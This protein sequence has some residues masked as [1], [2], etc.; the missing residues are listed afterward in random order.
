MKKFIPLTLTAV[1]AIAMVFAIAPSDY[2]QT[3]HVSTPSAGTSTDASFV[4]NVL[5]GAAIEDQLTV[6]GIEP[7]NAA[8][9]LTLEG[10]GAVG[11]VVQA[12]NDGNV[13][14]GQILFTID[15]DDDASD[16]FSVDASGDIRSSGSLTLDSTGIAAG[17]DMFTIGD[18]KGIVTLFLIDASGDVSITGTLDID[19]IAVAELTPLFT[20]G[21]DEDG[22]E[23]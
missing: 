15:D 20:I 9:A 13:G 5:T 16:L 8:T 14:E 18:P 17:E 11:V 2:A 4:A 10:T 7:E 22:A 12:G 23:K 1:I 21:D 3:S 19:S 6:D